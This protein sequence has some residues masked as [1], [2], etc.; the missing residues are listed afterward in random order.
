MGENSPNQV[1]LKHCSI[2]LPLVR[3]SMAGL[4]DFSWYNIS[5]R[6]KYAK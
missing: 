1:S 2:H 4:P 6:E 3:D 5:K